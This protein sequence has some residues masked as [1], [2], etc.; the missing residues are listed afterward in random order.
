[1]EATSPQRVRQYLTWLL[2]CVG[3]VVVIYGQR[4]GVQA[5]QHDTCVQVNQIK[6]AIR[7]YVDNQLDRSVKSLPTIGYYRDHPV[8]LGRQLAEINRQRE[9]TQAAFVDGSC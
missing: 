5:K 2:I 6:E 7:S 1:M 9:A 8:E 3:L 4:S